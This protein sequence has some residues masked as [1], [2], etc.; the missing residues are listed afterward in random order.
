[1]G[2][3]SSFSLLPIFCLDYFLF[4]L[5]HQWVLS[6]LLLSFLLLSSIVVTSSI[7]FST[8][9]LTSFFIQFLL[10]CLTCFL[11]LIRYHFL[12]FYCST[13]I[14]SLCHC[15]YVIYV[16]FL[17]IIIILHSLPPLLS[18][19]S[20]FMLSY[21]FFILYDLLP[22]FVFNVQLSLTVFF[23]YGRIPTVFHLYI[24]IPVLL[25]SYLLLY[26]FFFI[27][28]DPYFFFCF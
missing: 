26:L 16:A 21:L 22:S 27:L 9:R 24:T 23:C 4:G 14:I 2:L 8:F 15:G 17:F 28:D 19:L 18:Y 3:T 11:Y 5:L 7:Q 25:L 6:L 10:F 1:M 13:L 20:S 12:C